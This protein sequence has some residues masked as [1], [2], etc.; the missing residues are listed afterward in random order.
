[1]I[2][3]VKRILLIGKGAWSRK[4]CSAIGAPHSSW[5]IEVIS[6]RAFLSMESN[7]KE[8]TEMCKKFEIIWI[9]TTPENQILVLQKLKNTQKKII[10][11]KPIATNVSEIITLKE[12]IDNSQFKLYLSQPWTFSSFWNQAKKILSSIDGN[13]TIQANRGGNQ[14]RTGFPPEMDWAPH[15]LYL[16]TDYVHGL[17]QGRTDIHLVSKDSKENSVRLKYSIGTELIFQ[18]TAGYAVERIA[19]WE[20]YSNSRLLLS[21]NFEVRELTDCRG[22]D[23]IMY[24]IDSD[25]PI[26][27]MLTFFSENDPSIE[28]E[29]IFE[30][31]SHLVQNS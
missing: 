14:I 26:I 3:S 16:L 28:W 5:V 31:Y 11:E 18:I 17:G 24:K 12:I 23:P 2:S 6:A 10:L 4:V 9:T 1:M 13:V 25:N 8:F 22:A 7:S 27:T 19:F 15:D 29:L 21:L 30:L 20:V